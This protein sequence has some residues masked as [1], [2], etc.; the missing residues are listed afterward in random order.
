VSLRVARVLCHRRVRITC[1][2][3]TSCS[4]RRRLTSRSSASPSST[5]GR[6]RRWRS[7]WQEA[8][9]LGASSTCSLGSSAP[10]CA[11]L[12]QVGQR[13]RVCL[14]CDPALDDGRR[15]RDR[16][17]RTGEALAER[18]RRE[19]QRS[20]TRRVLEHGM[21][22]YPTGGGG[23]HR[24]LASAL[25]RGPTTFEPWLFDTHRIQSEARGNQQPDRRGSF[26]ASNG[27]KN[28]IRSEPSA[29]MP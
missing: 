11:S 23:D 29:Q 4:T 15:H 24:D 3:T 7:T 1:G 2:R 18:H 27:P 22:S 28:P 19:L 10:G 26:L 14:Q 16:A 6:G 25:Q 17:H 13:A 8:S 9:D 5:S 12:H 21:V 20:A